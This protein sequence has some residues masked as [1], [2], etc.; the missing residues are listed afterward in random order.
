M[1]HHMKPEIR[2]PTEWW[3][4]E[5]TDCLCWVPCEEAG[6]ENVTAQDLL[7]HLPSYLVHDTQDI[8]RWE[9]FS[10]YGARMVDP[11]G[12]DTTSWDCYDTERDA[13][14]CLA[15]AN[16]LC[17]M[18]LTLLDEESTCG[19]CVATLPHEDFESALHTVLE[20]VTVNE[21]LHTIP[22][23]YEIISEEYNNQALNQAYEEMRLNYEAS[24]PTTEGD[25]KT[26]P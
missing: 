11:E 6:R 1:A 25:E 23:I 8:M 12:S 2:G 24:Y 14:D 10:G 16:D 13:K 15:D 17:P 4:V 19:K 21:I 22:G 20:G 9:F 5:T 3:K 26:I 7:N 18:C